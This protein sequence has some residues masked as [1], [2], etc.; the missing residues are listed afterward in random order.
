[1]DHENFDKDQINGNRGQNRV[2]QYNSYFPHAPKKHCRRNQEKKRN[3]GPYEDSPEPKAQEQYDRAKDPFSFITRELF[4]PWRWSFPQNGLNHHY[5]CKAHGCNE[6]DTGKKSGTGMGFTE[7][8][9]LKGKA[10][11]EQEEKND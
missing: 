9:D 1:L 11:R 8:G 10:L 4:H 7:R 5:N 2:D 3:K 6:D